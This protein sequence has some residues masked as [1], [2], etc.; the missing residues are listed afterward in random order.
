MTQY[1]ICINWRVTPDFKVKRT[2][3]SDIFLQQEQCH[4]KFKF[5]KTTMNFDF[6]FFYK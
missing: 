1:V 6:D 4:S 3:F 5:N 2:H